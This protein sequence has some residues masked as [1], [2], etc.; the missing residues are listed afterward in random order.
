MLSLRVC[1]GTGMTSTETAS[2]YRAYAA[3]C[4]SLAQATFDPAGKLGLLDMGRAWLDLADQA[5]KNG[6]IVVVYE[7]SAQHPMAKK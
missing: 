3:R 4:I 6:E 5:E 7:A 2:R 1:A